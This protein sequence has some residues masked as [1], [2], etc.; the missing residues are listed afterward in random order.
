MNLILK[1][2]VIILLLF[3]FQSLEMKSQSI[4]PEELKNAFILGNSE[5]LASY[6]GKNI[7]LMLLDKGDVYSKAQAELIIKNFFSN[8]KPQSFTLE[9]ESFDENINYAVALLKAGKRNFRIFIAYR[10]NHKKTTVSQ[11]VISEVVEEE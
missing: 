11:L 3:M 5:K 1:A 10:K 6:F 2:P 4:F 7:D 9:S 8:N